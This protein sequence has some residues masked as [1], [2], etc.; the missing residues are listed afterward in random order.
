[1]VSTEIVV[2]S[3]QPCEYTENHRIIRFKMVIFFFGML[4]ISNLGYN[5]KYFRVG[6]EFNKVYCN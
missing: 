1:M 5:L 6:K 4:I 3:V 2:I